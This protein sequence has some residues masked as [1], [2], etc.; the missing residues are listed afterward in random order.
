MVAVQTFSNN[1]NI[2]S[3]DMMFSYL[4]IFDH[5]IVSIDITKLLHN[6]EYKSWGDSQKDI[7][8]SPMDVINNPNKKIY[9]NEIK[10][11]EKAKLSYPIII[12]GTGSFV[13]DGVHRLA[14]AFIQNKKTIKSYIFS[15]TL[16]KK[17]LI[18]NNRNWDKVNELQIY[19][20]IEL[21]NERFC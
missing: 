19:D 6:L 17:F 15:R 8:Y 16:M 11:I 13:V 14:K 18:N 10:R 3:V 4:H 1:K 9:K 5:R 21:F 7:H 20:Y 12:D 2:Y